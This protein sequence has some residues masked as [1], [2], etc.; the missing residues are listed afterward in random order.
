MK[1]IYI[2]HNLSSKAAKLSAPR[3]R[4]TTSWVETIQCHEWFL[5]EKHE[6][7]VM[8]AAACCSQVARV[9]QW[10]L[11]LLKCLQTSIDAS[12]W[13]KSSGRCRH[14]YG[15]NQGVQGTSEVQKDGIQDCTS[16]VWER[17]CPSRI[18]SQRTARCGRSKNLPSTRLSKTM[19]DGKFQLHLITYHHLSQVARSGFF[20]FMPSKWCHCTAIPK[21]PSGHQNSLKAQSSKVQRRQ[22]LARIDG[23]GHE[24]LLSSSMAQGLALAPP[25]NACC[26]L[27][28]EASARTSADSSESGPWDVA[29]HLSST[30]HVQQLRIV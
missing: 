18:R 13:L 23:I 4:D 19:G 16:H 14:V 20:H 2:Y 27:S 12:Y 11:T 7:Q 1:L 30:P 29:W 22:W 28:L 10:Q 17:Y 3:T 24:Q 8:T 26:W 25:G 5:A 6:E 15:G 21:R 9:Q